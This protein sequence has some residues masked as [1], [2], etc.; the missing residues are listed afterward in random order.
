MP[1]VQFSRN[2][3]KGYEKTI[4]TNRYL[5]CVF[6]YWIKW[7][8]QWRNNQFRVSR[9]KSSGVFWED[10][11]HWRDVYVLCELRVNRWQWPYVLFYIPKYHQW[12]IS[13]DRCDYVWWVIWLWITCNSLYGCS[14]SIYCMIKSFWRCCFLA[15]SH[16]KHLNKII[17]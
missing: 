13:F 8:H 10:N 11:N 15:I 9:S 6:L 17:G 3:G 16:S 14:N 4:S 12:K 2:G 7:L 5:C 1:V